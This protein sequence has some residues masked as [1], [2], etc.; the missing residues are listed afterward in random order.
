MQEYLVTDPTEAKPE[1][2]QG[3]GSI[4]RPSGTS[5]LPKASRYHNLPSTFCKDHRCR[6][7]P[8]NKKIR[9]VFTRSIRIEDEEE[10]Q[11][12]TGILDGMSPDKR[13][14]WAANPKE[15]ERIFEGLLETADIGDLDPQQREKVKA[16]LRECSPLFITSDQE[17][18]GKIRGLEVDIP[19]ERP[20]IACRLR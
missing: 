12:V 15:R 18:A 4:P 2:G 13:V 1:R 10:G 11:P 9:D 14:P 6:G 17:P 5:Q 3:E 16:L 7:C 8:Q 20:P 19:T